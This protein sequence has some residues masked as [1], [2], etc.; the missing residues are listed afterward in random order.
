MQFLEFEANSEL[1]KVDQIK[2]KWL[3]QPL[4][5]EKIS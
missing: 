3:H 2:F 5:I 4:K 1:R